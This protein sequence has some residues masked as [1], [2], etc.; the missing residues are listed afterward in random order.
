[1]LIFG[2]ISISFP[3]PSSHRR[4]KHKVVFV[5]KRIPRL[6]RIIHYQNINYFFLYFFFIIFIYSVPKFYVKLIYDAP[7]PLEMK[8]CFTRCAEQKEEVVKVWKSYGDNN[9]R[10]RKKP[11]ITHIPHLVKYGITFFFLAPSSFSLFHF[12]SF[13]TGIFICRELRRWPTKKKHV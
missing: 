9:S 10:R 3:P 1:M 6:T 13:F 12:S 11:V 4:C 5:R 7:R 8:I 2:N